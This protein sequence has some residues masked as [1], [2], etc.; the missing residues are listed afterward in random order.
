MHYYRV[1]THGTTDKPK[2]VWKGHKSDDKIRGKY[3]LVKDPSG[4]RK[5]GILEHRF[6]MEQYL[7]RELLPHENV[8]H[9]NGI[10]DDNRLEN[11]E[12]WTTSQPQ[13]QRVK[14]KVEWA[15][16]ILALYNE[17]IEKHAN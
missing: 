3:V 2:R 10:R 4:N 11:L 14:D 17:E 8:H 16:Q 6:V 12:L 13:G 1:R 9:K 7:G 5:R 15:K